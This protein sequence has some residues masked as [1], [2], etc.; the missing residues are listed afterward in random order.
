MF[1]RLSHPLILFLKRHLGPCIITT[2]TS[3]NYR[4]AIQQ[5]CVAHRDS[6]HHH[7][8]PDIIDRDDTFH[9]KFMVCCV[10]LCF[11]SAPHRSTKHAPRSR[12]RTQQQFTRNRRVEN[13]AS[14]CVTRSAE[15]AFYLLI[16]DCFCY[17]RVFT[18]IYHVRAMTSHYAWTCLE[19]NTT[20]L[21][22]CSFFSSILYTTDES[23]TGTQSTESRSDQ[24]Q[25]QRACLTGCAD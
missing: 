17:C 8:K 23:S 13:T 5:D 24:M 7:L 2:C 18:S 15:D 12:R 19:V 1:T 4:Y 11:F 3:N 10:T 16:R 9:Y 6:A 14:H 21:K 20:D 22:L 25:M